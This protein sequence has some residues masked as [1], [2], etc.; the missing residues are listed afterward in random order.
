MSTVTFSA[1]KAIRHKP[2]AFACSIITKSHD[3]KLHHHN[4]T[5]KCLL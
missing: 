2:P 1:V 3:M 5:I 4:V